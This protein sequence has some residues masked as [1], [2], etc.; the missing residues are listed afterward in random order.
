MDSN[1]AR[2]AMRGSRPTACGTRIR[3]SC[4]LCR[5]KSSTSTCQRRI[6]RCSCRSSIEAQVSCRVGQA[7]AIDWWAVASRLTR[8]QRAAHEHTALWR[9][10]AHR[11]LGLLVPPYKESAWSNPLENAGDE[12]REAL[13]AAAGDFDDLLDLDR[14]ERVGQA[15][16]GDDREAQDA[17]ARV[18][19]HDYL[20]DR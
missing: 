12:A 11:R 15:N 8:Q 18:C 3:A 2:A 6:T 16:V 1:G 20:G 10:T 13:A 17:Q 7:R 9:A 4:R 19:R 5:R 14:F